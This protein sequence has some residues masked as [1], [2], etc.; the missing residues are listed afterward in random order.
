MRGHTQVLSALRETQVEHG[1]VLD[2][3]TAALEAQSRTL[4][5]VAELVG[6]LMVGQMSMTERLT[7]IESRLGRDDVPEE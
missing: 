2:V 7:R 6:Q 3:H 4:Q 5:N 1:N